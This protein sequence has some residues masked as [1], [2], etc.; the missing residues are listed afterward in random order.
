[1]LGKAKNKFNDI[2]EEN[3]KRM[4]ERVCI[5]KERTEEEARKE[6]ERVQ[7]EKDA[8]LALSEKELIVEAIM[9]LRSYNTRLNNVEEKLDNL[10]VRVVSLDLNISSIGSSVD[11]LKYK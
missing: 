2:R 7:V 1:M 6:R 9:A 8:L 10:E 3:R 5:A 4:E 11:E